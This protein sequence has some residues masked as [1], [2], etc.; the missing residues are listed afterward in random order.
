MADMALLLVIFPSPFLK[1]LNQLLCNPL[2]EN[3]AHGERDDPLS[4]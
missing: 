3:L 2:V 4:P 1:R